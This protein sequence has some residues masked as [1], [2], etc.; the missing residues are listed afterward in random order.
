MC[1]CKCVNILNEAAWYSTKYQ[2]IIFLLLHGFYDA[3]NIFYHL[4]Q[5]D[6]I[7]IFYKL[8]RKLFITLKISMH[9]L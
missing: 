1:E 6:I 7:I 8:K 3:S 9:L 5:K 2:N 4:I